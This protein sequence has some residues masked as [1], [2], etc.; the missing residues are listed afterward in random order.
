MAL[1]LHLE[2]H[3]DLVV[4]GPISGMVE[5]FPENQDGFLLAKEVACEWKGGE[6]GWRA[7]GAQS[8]HRYETIGIDRILKSRRWLA[9]DE[10][11]N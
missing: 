3:E 4:E 6:S 9:Q 11:N 5:V 8:E 2:K 7:H 1:E 10:K